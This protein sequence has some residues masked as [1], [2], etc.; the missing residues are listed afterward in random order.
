VFSLSLNTLSQ[1]PKPTPTKEDKDV[2]KIS[3]T[4][5]QVDVT[6]TDKKGKPVR[7]L[8]AEDFEIFENG[9]KQNI[10][11][12]SFVS[13]VSE[14]EVNVTKGT[15]NLSI[16]A[17]APAKEI[18]PNEVRRTIALVVDDLSLS[19][20]STHYV[21]RALRNF[22][23]KQ[24]QSGDLVGIIR[25]SGG[26]GALQQFTS[27][28]NRLYAAIK[29]IKWNLTTSGNSSV[30]TPFR[31]S[32]NFT[33]TQSGDGAPTAEG[34]LDDF[35]DQIFA[36]GTLG[37]IQ[38]VVEGMAELPGRKSVMLM[39]DGFQIF[40]RGR[41]DFVGSSIVLD[42]LTRLVDAANRASV[43]VY[44]MDA[45][46]LQ[47]LDFTAADDLGSQP[48]R[49]P[50]GTSTTAV[51]QNKTEGLASQRRTA[52][53]SSQDGINFL[54]KETG[55]LAFRNTNDLNGNI[56]KMLDDQSYYLI[57]YQ[58]DSETFDPEKRRFNRLNVNVKRDDVNVR[59]RS[60]FFGLN[61]EEVKTPTTNLTADQKITKAL[62]S[63]FAVNDINLSLSTIFK[64]DEKDN[65][66]INS[67][68]RI[69]VKDLKFTDT[70]KGTKR[71]VFDLLIMNFGANGAPTDQLSKTFTIDTKGKTY[72]NIV[73][74]GFVYDVG[75]L[76]KKA[77]AYQMRVAIRDHATNKIG[78][79]NKFIQV[80]TLKK[81]GL[82]LSGI[83]V[84]NI[85]YKKWESILNSNEPPE[86]T[87]EKD[88]P[89]MMDTASPEFKKGTVLTYGF[90][91]YN[92]QTDKENNSQITMRTRL[93]R[94][95]KVI[96][97]GKDAAIPPSQNPKSKIKKATG[98]INLGTEMEPGEYI[99]QIIVTD[100]LAR[101][102]NQIATQ[103][104]QFEIVE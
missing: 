69:N 18:K 17:P 89:P 99:L 100:K 68:L 30:F 6:V 75:L 104:V 33:S 65:L 42:G 101:Q 45:R 34:G 90:D 84:D 63:P 20:E 4:L 74:N 98:A 14:N 72:Q 64:G 19:F 93:F 35:R 16:E 7:D 94:D 13:S 82:T 66:Y 87:E 37:A 78:S 57:S 50:D 71:A 60:G 43:V 28:K 12:V 15:E 23:E 22:V 25:T 61:D 96:F 97:E 83:I 80:P 59:Y 92:A 46:G 56:E 76:I 5:I 24:M 38:Y 95:N 9:E 103:Y 48:I 10:S 73:E 27:D 40:S 54:A 3:T 51:T 1:T 91:I 85:S 62:I 2:V 44:T 79:A 11:N 58:P 26:I 8:K 102:K 31:A 81:G 41:S 67:Y 36:G 21:R 49:S 86:L 39:S 77:G 32:E 52:F 88:L 70:E 53:R 47:T 29:K 55:G